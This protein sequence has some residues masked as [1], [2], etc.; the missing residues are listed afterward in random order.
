MSQHRRTAKQAAA[1]Q[2][3]ADYEAIPEPDPT[4]TPAEVA[5]YLR[6]T[7]EARNR[8]ATLLAEADAELDALMA[9]WH[10]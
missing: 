8:A 2:A 1:A 6:A 7:A 3:V 10:S 9:Q 4:S 5:E